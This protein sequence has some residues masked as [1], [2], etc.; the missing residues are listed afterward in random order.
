MPAAREPTGGEATGG[1]ATGSEASAGG[2][3]AGSE[4]TGSE[5]TGSEASAGEATARGVP[6]A[7][8]EL[9]GALGL[10]LVGAVL[11]LAASAPAWV[12]V[13]VPRARPLADATVAVAGRSLVPLVP[14][15]GLVGLAA[16]VG[17]VATRGRG[18]VLL[19]AVLALAGA[20]V[21]V[22]AVPHLAAPSGAATE[23]LLAGRGP[24][25][26]RDLARPVQPRAQPVWPGLA[27]VG[28]LL[29]AAAGTGAAVRGRRWP[30]MS[31]RYDAPAS[32]PL[33]ARPAARPAGRPTA[34]GLWD[35]LDRGDDPT[36]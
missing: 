7:R 32:R 15:L 26:G 2:G 16:L 33:D 14:A 17:L 28:G 30:A 8:R 35:A 10:C 11:A 31:G 19:G 5:A 9:L 25:P 1:E 24:L 20:A 3:A 22:A 27:A 23:G 21:V 36:A 4:V 34:A 12:R 13:T 18:R 29:L 6:A